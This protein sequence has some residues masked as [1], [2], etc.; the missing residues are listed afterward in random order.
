MPAKE[1]ACRRAELPSSLLA[2]LLPQPQQTM[3]LQP[4]LVLGL[5]LLLL[6]ERPALAQE[7]LFAD[8]DFATHAG[9]VTAGQFMVEFPGVKTTALALLPGSSPVAITAAANTWGSS[10]WYRVSFF[11]H[12]LHGYADLPIV[13]DVL[14]AGGARLAPPFSIPLRAA[15]GEWLHYD[16]YVPCNP[17]GTTTPRLTVSSSGSTIQLTGLS[18]T[19]HDF[20]SRGLTDVS[21]SVSAAQAACPVA[22]DGAVVE[23]PTDFGSV[24]PALSR[25]AFDNDLE[26]NWL[27]AA[28]VPPGSGEYPTMA[29]E[30]EF[31]TTALVCGVRIRF[32]DTAYPRSWRVLAKEGDGS[33]PAAWSTWLDARHSWPSGVGGSV[34]AGVPPLEVAGGSLHQFGV[35]CTQAHRLRLEMEG[36]AGGLF[37]KTYEIELLTPG[38][39][40]SSCACRHGGACLFC[41]VQSVCCS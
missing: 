28:E 40:E 7:E 31:S 24:P 20:A 9:R 12:A 27:I 23:C 21:W 25:N 26:T 18:I 34:A 3:L 1:C 15:R 19:W 5:L 8:G 41:S 11:A 30:L 16:E 6:G 39:S 29:L 38:N 36:S 13:V 4:L 22:S 10:G 2:M 33:S 35:S 32:D 14:D 17:S 37:Y